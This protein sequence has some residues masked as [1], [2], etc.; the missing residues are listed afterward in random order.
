MIAV[1]RERDAGVAETHDSIDPASLAHAARA[2]AERREVVALVARGVLARLELDE[3]F[4]EL[5]RLVGEH[6]PCDAA[7]IAVYRPD[8]DEFELV[9]VY[10]RG[11]SG[12][13]HRGAKI[14]ARDTLITIAFRGE[15]DV[16]IE[17]DTRA[18]SFPRARLLSE[19]GIITAVYLPVGE[20]GARRAVL[21]VG[22]GVANGYST[23]EINLFR[24]IVPFVALALRNAEIHGRARDGYR[25]LAEAQARLVQAE[26][27]RALGELASAV[28][29][30]LGNVLATIGSNLQLMATSLTDPEGRKIVEECQRAVEQGAR[31]V[32]RMIDLVGSGRHPLPSHVRARVDEA[33]REVVENVRHRRQASPGAPVHAFDTSG[34]PEGLT[35]CVDARE[36]REAIDHLVRNALEAMPQGG[37]ISF[38]ASTHVGVARI[39][40][41]DRGAGVDA[42]IAQR[43]Y[44]PFFTT[45]SSNHIGLGLAFVNGLASRYGGSV[46]HENL[47][48]GG[49]RFLLTLPLAP[50]GLGAAAPPPAK[51]ALKVLLVEDELPL[52]RALRELLAI[53]GFDVDLTPT[54][55][56]ALASMERAAYDVV[57]TDLGLP[58]RSGWDLVMAV[59]ARP[60]P[61]PVIVLSGWGAL[62][63]GDEARDR[64]AA[65]VLAKP[66]RDEE[67]AQVIARVAAR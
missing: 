65:A 33:V 52:G 4:P 5:I 8:E 58:G 47:E 30:D 41:E 10:P 2:E 6:C 66:V 53:R 37:T 61:P 59:R 13:I 40:I 42:T 28:A 38:S 9:S 18:S 64:G 26:R 16:H 29:H 35:V 31:S 67:L 45:K 54:V 55:D 49:A 17:A 24:D 34:V 7:S 20:P 50:A 23:H 25:E 32:Q 1:A 22:R 62:V 27:M 57:V 12:P 44:E 43:I 51:A 14:S 60:S 19:A 3:V 46:T 63:D 39:A 56:E 36:L 48:P 15:A 11:A 21:C